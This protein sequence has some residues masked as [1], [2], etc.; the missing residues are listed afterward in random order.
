MAAPYRYALLFSY[1]QH[2]QRPWPAM[3]GHG[4]AGMGFDYFIE[5]LIFFNGLPRGFNIPL[6]AMRMG[7]EYAVIT[8]ILAP[9]KPV[10]NVFLY[11]LFK[12]ATVFGAY[13]HFAV[14]DLYAGL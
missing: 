3:G 10:L 4:A 11:A 12:R 2:A 7:Y 8:D 13:A 14:H 6:G 1:E 9:L 5:A